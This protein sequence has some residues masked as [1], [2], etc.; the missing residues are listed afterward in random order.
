MAQAD[1]E[2]DCTNVESTGIMYGKA[3]A[4]RVRNIYEARRRLGRFSV[5]RWLLRNRKLIGWG[6][7][8][9]SFHPDLAFLEDICLV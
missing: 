3:V 5:A 8:G 4:E 2:L 7:K 9:L 6:R 1:S